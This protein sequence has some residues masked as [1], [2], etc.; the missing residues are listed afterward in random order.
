MLIVIYQTATDHSDYCQHLVHDKGRNTNSN[1][2]IKKKKISFMRQEWSV[3]W[4]GFFVG[5]FV[6]VGCFGGIGIVVGTCM[7]K[8]IIYFTCTRSSIVCH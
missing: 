5:F 7:Y 8:C 6:V 3:M 4:G 1:A 2:S